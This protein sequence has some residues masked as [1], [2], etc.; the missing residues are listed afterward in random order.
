MLEYVKAGDGARLSMLVLHDDAKREYAY[1]PAQ[2]LPDTKM[3]LFTQALHDE[4]KNQGWIVISMKNDSEMDLRVR[5]GL[6]GAK[7]LCVGNRMPHGPEHLAQPRRDGLKRGV[8]VRQRPGSSP[9][10]YQPRSDPRRTS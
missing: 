4:A 3:G 10:V 5:I 8:V 7:V 6:D 2:G 9:P 1:G